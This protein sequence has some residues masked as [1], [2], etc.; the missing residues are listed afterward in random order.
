MIVDC[1]FHTTRTELAD[2]V[3]EAVWPG[4]AKIFTTWSFIEKNLLALA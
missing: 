3:T 1:S 4:E 2:Y